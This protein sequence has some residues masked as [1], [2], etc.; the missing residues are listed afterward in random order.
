MTYPT[1]GYSRFEHSIGAMHQAERMLRAVWSQDLDA[2]PSAGDRVSLRRVRLAALLHDVGHLPLSHVSERYYDP[3]ECRD[4][5][6]AK[7]LIRTRM[8]AATLLQVKQP[9]LSEC[10][11]LAT[12]LCPRMWSFIVDECR[13]D[14]E[15]IA[16][17]A[18]AIVGRP[19]D[20]DDA[21]VA[22]LISNVID[23]DKLDY[24]FR[25]AA[26]T[27]TP[28]AVDLE[29]LL[30]KIRGVR[31]DAALLPEAL[32]Q[33]TGAGESWRVLGVDLGGAKALHELAVSRGMLYERVYLHQKTRAAERVALDLVGDLNLH[34]AEML[35]HD[36]ALLLDE[37]RH[38][39]GSTRRDL[40]RCL[41]N[42]DLPRRAF[43]LS[44]GFLTERAEER[45]GHLRILYDDAS[46]W[47]RLLDECEVSAR[48]RAIEAGILKE[49]NL[50]ATQLGLDGPPAI[51]LDTP[52]PPPKKH[53]SEFLLRL[54][55]GE[56]R[57]AREIP[58]FPAIA[59][60]LTGTPAATSYV[61]AS[62][63]DDARA[64]AF[65]A[66]ESVLARQLSLWFGESS[67]IYSKQGRARVD[68]LKRRIE[69]ASP[70][71][72]DGVRLLRPP[73]S[74]ARTQRVAERI[75]Q[76]AVRLATFKT[77]ENHQINEET[78]T[79]Y[80][81]QFP[82]HLVEQALELVEKVQYFGR[83]RL[84]KQFRSFLGNGHLVPLIQAPDKSA[85]HITYFLRDAGLQGGVST[86][87]EALLGESEAITLFDDCQI[88]GKQ[89]RTAVQCWLGLP[90]DLPGD[91][92]KIGAKKLDDTQLALL[93]TKN[94]QFRFAYAPV[95]GMER[96][97]ELLRENGLRGD[98]KAMCDSDRLAHKVVAP[99]SE[100]HTFLEEVGKELLRSTKQVRDP[101]KWTDERC[102]RC[103]LGYS[104]DQRL[105]VFSYNTPTGTLTALWSNGEYRG[106]PWRPLFPRPDLDSSPT[107]I[108]AS[109][110]TS[111]RSS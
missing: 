34:P 102:E 99:G 53:A 90:P 20:P 89:A 76:Q 49:A 18:L 25:D 84:G 52:L 11:S 101:S 96:L 51:W 93:R 92:P 31:V 109:A 14:A 44:Y 50:L 21:F 23:A 75:R 43:A 72:F 69:R 60:S 70:K 91:V 40:A 88:S 30:F 77:V 59:A 105:V 63:G 15:D 12:I 33:I 42:R 56:I 62:G 71:Y 48:R 38:P 32:K 57:P 108:T 61:Y 81:D 64:L 111:T 28:L 80:L 27:G 110:S 46:A 95:E 8:E 107:A 74:T 79:A 4:E 66:A 37:H 39:S 22:Q 73:S 45:G 24:M 13:Y 97:R 58:S 6:L 85:T 103:A 2:L 98:V 78:V 41:A 35:E 68:D 29:R 19:T 54:P 7:R 55:D 36:D 83:D 86:L 47:G 106:A 26:A 3:A 10:L 94:L 67:F 5:E 65:I 17:A 82:D 16:V 87:A 100:L 1:A 9:E 104:G